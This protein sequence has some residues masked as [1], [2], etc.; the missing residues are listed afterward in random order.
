MPVGLMLKGSQQTIGNN[1]LN[2]RLSM[3]TFA[4]MSP[5]LTEVLFF[6]HQEIGL[7]LCANSHFIKINAKPKPSCPIL[8]VI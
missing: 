6:Q 5:E 3:C 8:C 7:I 4:V 2:I 1:I